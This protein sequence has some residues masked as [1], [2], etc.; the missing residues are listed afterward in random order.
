M[1]K[2]IGSSDNALHQITQPPP[3]TTQGDDLKGIMRPRMAEDAHRIFVQEYVAKLKEKQPN[4]WIDGA[5]S[6]SERM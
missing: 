2:N 3:A 4:V 1:R 5:C 6:D